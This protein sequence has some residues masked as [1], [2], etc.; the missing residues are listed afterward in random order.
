MGGTSLWDKPTGEKPRSQA[1]N[2]ARQPGIDAFSSAKWSKKDGEGDTARMACI[3]PRRAPA[4]EKMPYSEGRLAEHVGSKHGTKEDERPLVIQMRTE[5]IGL[6]AFLHTRTV[7]G[8]ESVSRT[9][10]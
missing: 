8:V 9:C 5:N 2:Q 3:L 1:P 6:A 10:G 4:R 7:P